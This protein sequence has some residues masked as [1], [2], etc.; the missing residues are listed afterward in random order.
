MGCCKQHVRMCAESYVV[1]VMSVKKSDSVKFY[2]YHTHTHTHIHTHAHT[3]TH[4]HTHTQM[5]QLQKFNPS[6]IFIVIV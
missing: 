4:T 6:Q 5:L 2:M 3:H 1:R